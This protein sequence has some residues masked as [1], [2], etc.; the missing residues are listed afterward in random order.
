MLEKISQLTQ[1]E[2]N[3]LTDEIYARALQ[4]RKNIVRDGTMRNVP[5]FSKV[6]SDASI[7]GY[8]T[9]ILHV[10][11][12]KPTALARVESRA[13]ETGRKV[14]RDFFDIANPEIINTSAKYLKRLSNFYIK[15]NN[16]VSPEVEDCGLN[17]TCSD[18]N[19][20]FFASKFKKLN[21]ATDENVKALLDK[22]TCVPSQPLSKTR[23]PIEELK[24]ASNSMKSCVSIL[25]TN[26]VEEPSSSDGCKVKTPA[27]EIMPENQLNLPRL[28][29][30]C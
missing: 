17:F 10:D 15:I 12:A 28:L 6:I 25:I 23:V 3:Y 24:T 14:N 2:A 22:L 19:V 20:T 4:Q 21:P 30:G 9:G 16:E 27:D 26:P 29:K 8:E 7:G 5:F 13:K 18:T 1:A 11:V